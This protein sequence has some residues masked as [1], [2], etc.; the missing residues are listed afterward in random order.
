[1]TGLFASV[2]KPLAILVPLWV[3]GTLSTPRALADGVIRDG[4][5]AISSGRG[6]T[7]IAH[8][9]NGEILLDNPA[10]MVNIEG[11]RLSELSADLLITDL[12]YSE[13][14]PPTN[15]AYALCRPFGLAQVSFIKKS[16]DGQ[17]AAG[18]GVFGP[19]GFGATYNLAGPAELAG[20]R[21]Y[22]SLGA[23]AKIL[24]G[25][26]CRL[27]DCVSVGA[28]LGVG[29]SH[30]QLEG[31]FFI[32]TGQMSG[33]PTLLDLKATG[34]TLVWSV[35][36]QH[37]LSHRTV[38]GVTYTSE[39]R[40]HLDGTADA[41]ILGV[42]GEFDAEVDLAW[43]RSVG[44]GMKHRLCDN[45]RLSVDVIWFN[46]SRAF[47]NIGLQLSNQTMAVADQFPLD[48]YDSISVRLGYEVFPTPCSVLRAGYV[49]N[50]NTVPS[51]TLTPYIPAT[52]E[53]AF[54]VGCG[55]RR[56]PWSLDVAYQFSFGPDRD[57]TISDIVGGD[58][59]DSRMEAQAH[60][61]FVSLLRQL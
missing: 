28:T 7:N 15:D 31:P 27:T 36:M 20:T 29:I 30:A 21:K 13:F 22:R 56:G 32:Q 57:V 42:P 9:D 19:A 14:S 52:L 44:V 10:G 5:G 24:P 33:L 46:W 2:R 40:F 51:A 38:W 39:S 16:C 6:G 8:S 45:R 34:H 37:E 55:K 43:P 48:W 61:I 1:M 4:L 17:W 18:L 59:N 35:G 60:W 26:S 58:F 54:S 25:L 49:Y 53:H 23:L 50:S 11:C 3:A 47:D 12:H 41:I